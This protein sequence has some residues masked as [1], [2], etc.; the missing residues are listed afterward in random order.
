M[1]CDMCLGNIMKLPKP[2]LME[3]KDLK[4]LSLKMGSTT[5]IEVEVKVFEK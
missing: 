3:V 2:F 5:H 1:G 4:S